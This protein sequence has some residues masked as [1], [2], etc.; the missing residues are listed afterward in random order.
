MNEEKNNMDMG[1][2]EE[3]EYID[4]IDEDGNSQTYEVL[5][6]FPMGET[7]Y[8][9]VTEAFE[10]AEDE[11]DDAEDDEEEI[12]VM[13]LRMETDDEGND[14]FVAVDDDDEAE[15]AF[16]ALEDMLAEDGEE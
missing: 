16:Q 12:P 3:T 11:T 4:L 1:E 10:E 14:I 6:S 13:L 7:Q 2:E 8:V 9:A 15:K 5:A